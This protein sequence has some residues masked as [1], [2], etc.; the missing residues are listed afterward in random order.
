MQKK[1]LKLVNLLR[2]AKPCY[3]E[4]L[5]LSQASHFN[6]F[7]RTELCDRTNQLHRSDFFKISLVIGEGVLI[8]EDQRIEINGNVLVLYNPEP[9][10]RWESI[11][12]KDTG[13]FCYFDYV[14]LLL[15]WPQSH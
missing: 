3:A 12:Y 1:V 13:Y 14:L 6:V 4:Y 15:S 5:L 8:F 9:A 10:Y 11:S 2:E 7:K